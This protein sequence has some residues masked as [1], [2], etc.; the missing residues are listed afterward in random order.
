MQTFP[1]NY[2]RVSEPRRSELIAQQGGDGN[3]EKEAQ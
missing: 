3:S 1:F 2:E